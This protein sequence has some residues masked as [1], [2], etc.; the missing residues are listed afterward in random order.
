MAQPFD[1]NLVK[2]YIARTPDLLNI[3]GGEPAQWSTKEVGD[4]N[5]NFVWIVEGPKGSF[6]LKQA[7]DYVRIAPAWKLTIRR[8]WWERSALVEQYKHA[9]NHVP[10]QYHFDQSLAVNVMEYLHPHVILRRGLMDCIVYPKLAEHVSEFMAA[11][12]FHTSDLYLKSDEKRKLIANFVD[13]AL[14]HLTETVIFHE[15]YITHP[16]N[17]WTKSQILENEI[18]AIHSDYD[19]QF[20]VSLLKDKFMNYTQALIHGDLHTGSLMVTHCETKVIDP[21]FAFFGPIGFDV[22]AYLGNIWLSYISQD[23]HAKLGNENRVEYKKWL[24]EQSVL[25]WQLFVEKFIHLWDTKAQGHL[26]IIGDKKKIQQKFITDLLADTLGFAGC[27]MIRR[28]IGIAHVA[29]I[30]SIKDE[31]IRAECEVKV[32]LFGQRLIKERDTFKSI[33]DVLKAL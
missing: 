6:V 7:A 32:L 20:Q 11:T 24:A 10:K 33:H 31:A 12:L 21:E 9:P 30:E 22:G 18:I 3:I 2:D 8:T 1:Q 26:H 27:K 23:G 19:L 16:N 15:P 5:I 28:I 4:G 25:T 14:I 17:H 29:D 13:N